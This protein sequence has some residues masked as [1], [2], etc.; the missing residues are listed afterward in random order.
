MFRNLASVWLQFT[1][2]SENDNDVT[3]CQHVIVKIF[4][5]FFVSLV[6]FS[7][8]SK[9]HVNVITGSGI[10]IISSYKELTRHPKIVNITVWVFPNIWKLGWVRNTRFYS[11]IL[12][13]AEK[14]GITA[15]TISELFR[16]KKMKKFKSITTAYR[17]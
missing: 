11:E 13:N 4:W 17:Q 1:G 5:Y 6:R 7:Y 15:F 12:L 16:I 9:F 14:C 3:I 10:M 2:T 8:W